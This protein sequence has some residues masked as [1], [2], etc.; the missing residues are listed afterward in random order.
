MCVPFLITVLKLPNTKLKK[1]N[2]TK[3]PPYNFVWKYQSHVN[4]AHSLHRFWFR[5]SSSLASRSIMPSIP[6]FHSH[7]VIILFSSSYLLLFVI[8][9]S[10]RFN[11][12]LAQNPVSRSP[13]RVNLLPVKQLKRGLMVKI[14]QTWTL[15][16]PKEDEQTVGFSTHLPRHCFQSAEQKSCSAEASW[17]RWVLFNHNASSAFVRLPKKLFCGW[18]HNSNLRGW[19]PLF[20]SVEC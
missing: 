8:G 2:K 11:Q 15:W 4:R 1:Q 3:K 5:E 9:E 7:T 12:L 16:Q 14:K 19:S 6:L 20:Q 18:E 10:M 17:H 13:N